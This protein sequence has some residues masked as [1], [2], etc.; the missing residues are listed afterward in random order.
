M[1][2]K[3]RIDLMVAALWVLLVVWW[4]LALVY[5]FSD[6]STFVFRTVLGAAGAITTGVHV[7]ST[8]DWLKVRRTLTASKGGN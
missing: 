4:V 1:P 6:D 3:R 2:D 5:A 7:S 8:L